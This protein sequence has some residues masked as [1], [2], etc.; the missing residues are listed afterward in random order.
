MEN[1]MMKLDDSELD[2]VSGGSIIFNED[3]TTCGRNCTDQYRVLDFQGTIDYINANKY[4]MSEKQM[5][6][7]MVSMGYLA[8]L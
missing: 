8:N 6:Q 3:L 7:N 1:K 2:A 5:I 4:S